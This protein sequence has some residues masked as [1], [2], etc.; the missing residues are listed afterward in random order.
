MSKL[1][2]A[3]N[4]WRHEGLFRT[5]GTLYPADLPWARDYGAKLDAVYFGNRSG[6][7]ETSPIIDRFLEENETERLTTEQV[8]ELAEILF[9]IYGVKWKKLYDI[10]LLE[11]N[12]IQNYDM[13]EEET[14]NITKTETPNIT[15]QRGTK[16]NTDYQVDTEQT[17]ENSIYGFNSSSP[18]P[19]ADGSGNNT[20]RTHG[21]KNNNTV[22]ETET[23]TGSRT[24]TETGT[25]K[26]TRKGNIGVTTSQQM[27]ESEI[28]LWDWNFFNTVFDDVDRELTIPMYGC[29]V[30]EYVQ[31]LIS[32]TF[33]EN[34]VY[35]A[36]DYNA[37]GFLYVVV[38]VSTHAELI[39][40]VI[41]E[42]GTYKASD[43]NAD[44]FSEVTVNVPP[45][46][47]KFIELIERSIQ[48]ITAEDLAGAT[49]IGI[50]S[51]RSCDSLKSVEL[52]N[53]VTE[54]SYRAAYDAPVI[55]RWIISESVT[56]IGQEAFFGDISLKNIVIKATNPPTLQN[57][58][59]FGNTNYCTI[60]VP[61]PDDYR[62]TTNWVDVVDANNQ[63]RIFPLVAT[64]A[65]LANIDTST[66]TKACVI[67]TDESYKEYTWDGSQWNEVV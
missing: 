52:S 34:G 65:D 29:Y 55:E 46:E 26:L 9:S 6:D 8:N 53:T 41:T 27:I 5:L 66:Y 56:R 64:V 23:E 2:K 7:K 17:V 11:Y 50:Y 49:K 47:N 12:P 43:Y 33:T 19:S 44:G 35:Y 37:D 59:A 62:I 61:T 40:K 3:F 54:I 22:D 1:I 20:V 36:T 25:R 21:D 28:A 60:Y 51:L 30:P 57:A 32:K 45:P 39:E 42:N 4:K 58:N 67:G 16:T 14:P 63:S 18:V 31:K 13:E 24:E 15:K 10:L 48:S 38:D